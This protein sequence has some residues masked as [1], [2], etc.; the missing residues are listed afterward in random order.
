MRKGSIAVLSLLVAAVAATAVNAR[1][2]SDGGYR[3]SRHARTSHRHAGGSA[4]TSTTCLTSAARNLLGRIRNQFGN[5][6]DPPSRRCHRGHQNT[7]EH[8]SCHRFPRTGQKGRGELP[9]LIA[10]HHGGVYDDSDMNITVTSGPRFVASSRAGCTRA[11]VAGAPGTITFLQQRQRGRR[12]ET[13]GISK[14]LSPAVRAGTTLRPRFCG[15]R[16]PSNTPWLT[17]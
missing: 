7:F 14:N 10:N 4:G 6:F 11:A 15:G 13:A 2:Y 16:S 8:A 17:F 9:R 1:S 5:V 3:Y 12:R